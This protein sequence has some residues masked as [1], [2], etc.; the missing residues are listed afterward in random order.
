V[1]ARLVY[2]I[3]VQRVWPYI[4]YGLPAKNALINKPRVTEKSWRE[5]N[6]F[7]TTLISSILDVNCDMIS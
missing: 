6:R 4:H 3:E 5:K 7:N 1:T 2:S